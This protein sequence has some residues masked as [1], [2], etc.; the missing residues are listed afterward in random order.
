MSGVRRLFLAVLVSA[1]AALPVNA[2]EP[3]NSI[4]IS[5]HGG[6]INSPTDF[7]ADRAVDYSSGVRFGG[8]LA[9]QLYERLSIRGDASFTFGSG[10]DVT[11]GINEDVS[12]D[13]QFYGGGV[14]ILLATG[15][16]A[17]PYVYG[18][19]G[20]IVVDRVGEDPITSYSFDVT[21]FTGVVGAGVRYVFTS[22]TFVFIDGTGWIYTNSILD[23]GQF[24]TSLS[25]GLGYRWGGN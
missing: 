11:G 23:E 24:D 2:Q 9:L 6:L 20:L 1:F 16:N 18:G 19:G 17:E 3:V 8:G 25:V 10:T 7:D 21:E 14:E 13:R 12:L 5:A 15:G 4:S 22:N